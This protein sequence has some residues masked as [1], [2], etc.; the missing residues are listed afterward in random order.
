MPNITSEPHSSTV[1]ADRKKLLGYTDKLTVRPNEVIEFK[2]SSETGSD[3]TA[4]LVQ[5][6]NGDIYSDAANYKE[7]ELESCINGDYKGQFQ[8]VHSG[9][10]IVIN[11]VQPLAEL[12]EFTI[13]IT[14][15][16]TLPNAGQ[17]HLISH[18]EALNNIGWSLQLND[19]GRLT[20]SAADAL[21]V[22]TTVAIE[23]PLRAKTWYR[24]ALRASWR[25]KTVYLD[26]AQIPVSANQI[27]LFSTSVSAAKLGDFPQ[28]CCPFLMAA[29]YGGLDASARP[30]PLACFNGRLEA[31]VIY[32]GILSDSEL[33]VVATGERP[34]MLNKHLVADWDF[35][36]GI[37]GAT[38]TD[39]SQSRLHGTT[40]NMPL[41]AVKGSNWN[42]STR[43]WVRAPHQYAAIHFH[44]DD[45]YDC[46]WL[47]DI[48]YTVPDD[49]RSG[50]YALRLRLSHGE[51]ATDTF[52]EMTDEEYLPFFVAAPKNKPQ[53]KLAFLLPTNTYLAYGNNHLRPPDVD[54]SDSD[55]MG[56]GTK[57]YYAQLI[58]AHYDL[59][60]SVYDHHL[61]G[62]PVHFS[63]CF[64]PLLNMRPKTILW[65]FCADLLF[66]DW[67]AEK[68]IDYDIITDDLLQQ[69]GVSLLKQYSAVMT[70][71]HPE[72]PTME[73]LDAIESYTSQGG[74]FM[75]MGGNGFYW[76]AA[77][78]NKLPGVIEVRRGRHRNP[79]WQSEVGESFFALSGKAGG[80][81]AHHDRPPCQQFGVGFIAMGPGASYYRL[82]AEAQK[83]RASFIIKGVDD[84]VI[85]SFGIFEGGAAGQE[86]D[87]SNRDLG[88]PD[89]AIVLARSENHGPEMLYVYEELD[90]DFPISEH[91]LS[92]TYAEVVFFET[93]G[94]GAVFS[95]GSMTWCGSLSYNDYDNSISTI[96]LNVI[97]RFCDAEP[98]DYQNAN[99]VML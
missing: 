85:G 53:A 50:I 56:P 37:E 49:L 46:G 29:A 19:Q 94:G 88:T 23:Q 61:D 80:T 99:E 4:Q 28:V 82:T 68:A 42:G 83:S 55:M 64:R 35:S 93:P 45:L 12:D 40:H 9:S 27:D 63:S 10:C 2:I 75:Y 47:S 69:E 14:V 95:V 1:L 32:R 73:Q 15:M 84:E 16:P 38:I 79:I 76:C 48:T 67:M 66:T 17:Q 91:Y 44:S 34:V 7:L 52:C 78:N 13:V 24:V 60:L 6:I 89:H 11:D 18:Q 41:R 54:Y 90:N 8:P 22:K 21:G 30:I 36:E 25:S 98:F 70:G 57:A 26:C 96:T 3:Y 77:M 92:D 86:I 31:P 74:R 20:F 5:L 59:G 62:S 81:W 65:T 39:R 43:E 72:Y 51:Q 87:R 33:A 97:Q 58:D 71:N